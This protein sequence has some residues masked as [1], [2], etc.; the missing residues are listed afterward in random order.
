MLT[1]FLESCITRSDL[2]AEVIENFFYI[3]EEF[4]GVR[5]CLFI[6][7]DL[8]YSISAVALFPQGLCVIR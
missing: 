3:L 2:L 4:L 5:S 6:D 8:I 1:D 7:L